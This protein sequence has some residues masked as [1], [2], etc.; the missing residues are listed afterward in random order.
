MRRS[1]TAAGY[2]VD[3]RVAA[4]RA[5]SEE[6]LAAGAGDV[7]LADYSLPHFDAHGA[8]ELASRMCP[9]TPFICV[10]GTIGEEATVELLKQGADDCVLKSRLARLPF[11]VQRAIDDRLRRGQLR[12]SEERYRQLFEGESDAVFLIDNESGAIFE[13]N[14]AAAGS[15][16]G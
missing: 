16:H 1:L 6:L 7:I 13:A 8:L 4:G 9:A 12:E 14:I 2:V 3:V 10:S 5:S 11:A 15:P